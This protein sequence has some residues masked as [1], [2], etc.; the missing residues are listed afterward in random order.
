VNSSYSPLY[1]GSFPVLFRAREHYFPIRR[2]SSGELR[3]PAPPR[4]AV[5]HRLQRRRPPPA[6][7]SHLI[8]DL[9]LRSIPPP[10][11]NLLIT[12]NPGCSPP[13]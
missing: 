10:R 1:F 9:R 4:V 7:P 2:R 13:L 5:H 3:P 11:S 6:A 8:V 12:V